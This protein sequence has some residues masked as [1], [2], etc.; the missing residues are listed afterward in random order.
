MLS[1]EYISFLNNKILEYLPP[2]FTKVGNKYNGRCFLCGDSR[3]NSRKKRG[4]FYTNTASYYCFNCGQSLSG[5]KLLELLSG[6]NYTDIRKEYTRL[7]LKSGLNPQ[8]SSF[9]ELPTDEPSIFKLKSIIKPEW[10]QP[11]SKNAL[12]YLEKR[13]VLEAPYFDHKLYS[14]YSKRKNEEYILIPWLLNGCEAYYQINDFQKLHSIKYIFPKD[15][16][17]LI[18]GLDNIDISW[19]YIICFEGFYDSIFVKNGVCVG[20]K[21]ITQYQ[22]KLIKERYPHH[23]IVIAFDNDKSGIASTIKLLKS[24][25]DYD[26]KFF[27]WYDFNT[28]EKDINDYIISNDNVNMFTD[29]LFLEKFIV[30]KLTMKMFLIKNNLWGQITTDIIQNKNKNKDKDYGPSSFWKKRKI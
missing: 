17:K 27:K 1:Y 3:K 14:C 28:T 15:K 26:F 5:I 7:F 12:E 2:T 23:Q 22:I 19:P 4:W 29:S 10:K 21:S 16:K 9:T 18:C 24:E 11:L 30:D 20:T 6:N 13:R 25:N 8:L